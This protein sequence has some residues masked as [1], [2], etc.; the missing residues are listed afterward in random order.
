ML[1]QPVTP[2]ILFE[3]DDLLVV[4]KPAG[5]NTHSPDPYHGEGLYEWLRGRDPRWAN[6][7]I[8]HRL[9][10]ETSGVLV[11]GK[12][13]EANR[14]LVDQFTRGLIRKEYQFLTD[15]KPDQ[16]EFRLR[17][18]LV[19]VGD[20]YVVR[21][22][23]AGAPLAET[24]FRVV[25]PNGPSW[26]MAA[27]PLTGRTHQIR[28]HAAESQIPSLGDVRYGGTPAA[29]L[30][31]Q[32]ASLSLRHPRSGEEIRFV[33]PANFEQP[34]SGLLRE[35]IIDAAQTDAYRL[36]HGAA[37]GWPGWYVDRLGDFLLS[38]SSAPLLDG[39][40]EY[41]EAFRQEAGLRGAYHKNLDRRLRGL[42]PGQVCPML[43][44][45]EAAPEAFTVRENGVRFRLSFAEGY[46]VGLFLDQRDNRRRMLQKYLGSK[47]IWPSLSG[48]ASSVLNLFAYTCGFSVCAA[49]AGARVT[50]VDLSRKYLDWGKENFTLNGLDAA[51]HEFLFGDVFDWLRRLTRKQAVF[52]CV[53]L[54]PPT[55]ST[56]KK[57]GSFRAEKDFPEVLR[58]ALPLVRTGGLVFAS[59]NAAGLA[60]ERFV[61]ESIAAVRSAGRRVT[62]QLYAP[63]PPDF[64]VTK[65]E[66]AY[67][68][69]L[70]LVVA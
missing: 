14:S 54:D 30:C 34:T 11:L 9:D 5:W 1:A 46:S 43:V 2:F 21:P 47:M 6:L 29:R 61:T 7:A 42:N 60:P 10:K 35:A 67:L 23:H 45:G 52:D 17:S 31:L 37:D 27:E 38:Q 39:Q 8:I 57:G 40:R 55:F 41:L 28:V 51:Q 53:V 50:S 32:A 18:A 15:R 44:A 26:L 25:R 49:L 19:R 12:S 63:Q 4:N 58:A 66:S 59:T 13:A 33:A 24:R 36:I 68:K 70:W 69:T 64:P 56:S 20:K 16:P 62:G 3:D 65:E 22:P 48:G